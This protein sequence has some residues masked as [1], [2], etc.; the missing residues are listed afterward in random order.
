MRCVV[1][2][3]K[4]TSTRTQG[5][6]NDTVKKPRDDDRHSTYNINN[7]TDNNS[8]IIY[9]FHSA[10]QTGLEM[11]KDTHIQQWRIAAICK[12]PVKK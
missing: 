10:L 11:A 8:N 9:N 7:N 3:K 2:F 5:R 6:S 4:L 12:K 1:Q